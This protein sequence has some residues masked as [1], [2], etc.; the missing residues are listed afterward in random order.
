VPATWVHFLKNGYTLEPR[1]VMD[2]LSYALQ[3][4]IFYGVEGDLEQ[5]INDSY[6]KM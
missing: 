5:Q 6:E 2:L 3:I 1:K 4:V